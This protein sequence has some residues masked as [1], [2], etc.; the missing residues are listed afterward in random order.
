M[1]SLEG[2]VITEEVW[3][4]A[5]QLALYL[6]YAQASD[7]LERMDVGTVSATSLHREVVNRGNEES[8]RQGQRSHDE[9]IFRSSPD[10]R[11]PSVSLGRQYVEMDGCFVHK[12]RQRANFEL[13]VGNVFRAPILIENG[14]RTWIPHKEYVGY[15]GD[16]ERFG[17]RLFSFAERWSISEAEELYVL[18]D[19]ASWIRSLHSQYFPHGQLILDWWHVQNAAWKAVGSLVS[20][21]C[22]R[23]RW[24]QMLTGSLFAGE[25]DQ[26]LRTIEELP[27]TT[28]NREEKRAGLAR[29]I[30]S[31]RRW[32]P[33]YQATK[34]QGIHI[35]SGVIE[36]TCMDTVGRRMKHRGMGWTDHGAEAMLCLRLIHLNGQWDHYWNTQH[37]ARAA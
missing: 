20:D 19:G 25:V 16:S 35:G 31:N 12:W 7:L 22:D 21:E 8:A 11:P 10:P 2:S 14:T 33:N 1:E 6:P 32:I 5:L 36:N 18:G 3:R 24:G 4:L 27:A 34:D 15:F 26:A 30:R 29:Y 17:E 28:A 9:A 37:P 23:R 13:K